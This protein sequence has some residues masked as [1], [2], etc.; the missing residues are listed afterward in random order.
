MKIGILTFHCA[1]NYGAVL[2]AYGLQEYLKNLGHEVYIIDYR[3]KYL[4]LPYKSF[5]CNLAKKNIKYWLRN[6]LVFLIRKKRNMAFDV[7]RKSY[8]NIIKFNLTKQ[9]NDFDIFF[10]GSDQIWNFEIT[11]GD[12]IYLGDFLASKG[13]RLIA[14]GA[15]VGSVLYVKEKTKVFQQQ[16]SKFNLIG[17]REQSLKNFLSAFMPKGAIELTVDPVLLAGE[18]VYKKIVRKQRIKIKEKYLLLFQL[19]YSSEAEEIAQKIAND[20]GLAIVKILS[21]S[22]SIKDRKTISTASPELFLNYIISAEYI[23]TTSFHGT[24]F[25]I[26]FKKNFN[27][28]SLNK[29]VSERMVNLLSVLEL[30]DRLITNNQ[31]KIITDKIDYKKAGEKL[32][33]LCLCSERFVERACKI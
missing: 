8:L 12:K 27:I 5:H 7:F 17:V 15:S 9:E 11:G 22:E 24:V 13:K 10:L 30:T 32:K 20:K 29:S 28:I 14:Y 3:P 25:S 16:L 1:N 31:L 4:L 23:V 33:D 2:Q 6:L 21:S 19:D 18:K 26:L